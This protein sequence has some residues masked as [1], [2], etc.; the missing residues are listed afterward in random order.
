MNVKYL[1]GHIDKDVPKGTIGKTVGKP[2]GQTQVVQFGD[3][4]KTCHVD[5]LKRA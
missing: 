4:R 5:N 1:G 3:I 2:I